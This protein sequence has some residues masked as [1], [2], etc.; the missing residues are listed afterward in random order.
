MKIPTL[1]RQKAAGERMGHPESGTESCVR[2][3]LRP[4]EPP[5]TQKARRPRRAQ[6]D[7]WRMRES[8]SKG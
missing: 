2:E 8:H 4:A 6:H 3:M 5:G 7:K 1:S